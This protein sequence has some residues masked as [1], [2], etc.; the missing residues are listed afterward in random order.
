MSATLD[1]DDESV[2]IIDTTTTDR[3]RRNGSTPA[4]MVSV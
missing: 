1:D 2:M 3:L 4:E